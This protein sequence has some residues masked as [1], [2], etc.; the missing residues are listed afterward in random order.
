M[1]FSEIHYIIQVSD[2]QQMFKNTEQE[3]MA[4]L[5]RSEKVQKPY[6]F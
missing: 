2:N 4:A 5:Y 1:F 6:I 3:R